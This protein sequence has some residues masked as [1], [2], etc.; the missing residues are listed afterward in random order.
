MIFPSQL[1]CYETIVS[2][3]AE[4]ISAE[5]RDQFTPSRLPVPVGTLSL[6]YVY[7]S[8]PVHDIV[9][10]TQ[11]MSSTNEF[12]PDPIPALTPSLATSLRERTRAVLSYLVRTNSVST[13]FKESNILSDFRGAIESNG[14]SDTTFETF[15]DN[16]PLSA[17][18]HYLPFVSRLFEQPCRMSSIENLMAPGFPE[19]VAH[20]SGTSSGAS[21]H[22]LK[23]RHPEHMSTG[24]SQT[25][26]ASSA[27]TSSGGKS[28][29]VY[30]LRYRQVVEAVD[31]DGDVKLKMPVCLM[32]TGTVRMFNQMVR[33]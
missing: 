8:G 12:P 10:A 25:M 11:P 19:F 24:T 20:S 6:I 27:T 22:F 17:Y 30:S 23:Y 31:D 13:F 1:C 21:K 29:I 5:H 3:V 14:E 15:H 18:E 28:C 9:I 4:R 2:Q 26:N 16:V 7:N 33:P 32:S